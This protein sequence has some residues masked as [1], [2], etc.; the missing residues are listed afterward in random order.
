MATREIKT[1]FKLEG[2]DDYKNSLKKIC[3]KRGSYDK[4]AD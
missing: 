1:R 4:R 3:Q 2:D